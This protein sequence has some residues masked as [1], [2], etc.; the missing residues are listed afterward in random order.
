MHEP[1]ETNRRTTNGAEECEDTEEATGKGPVSTSLPCVV[2]SKSK[3]IK[4]LS[5]VIVK[6]YSLFQ[7]WN[8]FSAFMSHFKCL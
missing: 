2:F 4:F 8:G 5:P 7:K 1:E 3:G 6:L